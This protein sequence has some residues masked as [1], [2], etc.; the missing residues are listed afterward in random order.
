MTDL[1]DTVSAQLSALAPGTEVRLDWRINPPTIS[2][3]TVRASI[4]ESGYVA[5]VGRQGHGVQRAY[6]FALLRTLVDARTA[7][8]STDPEDGDPPEPPPAAARGSL[9]V[10]VE[11]PE[12]YQH[13]VR[14]QY[15]SRT[16]ADL[17]RDGSSQVLYATHSPYFAGVERLD[18]IRLFRMKVRR[19]GVSVTTYSAF[20]A[21]AAADRLNTA[22][23]GHGTPWTPA[24]LRTQL[25]SLLGTQVG[26]GLFA[27]AVV[28][29]EGQE[30]RGALRGTDDHNGTDLTADGIAVVPVDGKDNLERAYVLYKQLA[31]PVYVL[32]D[33]DND[34]GKAQDKQRNQRLTRL[35]A[36]DPDEAPAT[37]VNPTWACADP[38]LLTVVGNETGTAALDAALAAAADDLGLD[39]DRG[40]KNGVV[41]RNAVA[42]LA[43]SGSTST[44][45][46]ALLTAARALAP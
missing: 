40:R 23:G 9:M 42:A 11:E 8:D 46:Q 2:A 13:P 18:A 45:L 30:D 25:A 3:P 35:L 29:V 39:P 32:F 27:R 4:A 21:Q 16:L 36:G 33:S 7:K 1:Q 15:L 22:V 14:S 43:A 31:V 38:N 10:V 24:R 41:V 5:E 12:L 44:T 17:A 34:R 37:E 6:V 28:L 19:D 26:D 20:D